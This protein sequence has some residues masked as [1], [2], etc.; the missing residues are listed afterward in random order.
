[1]RWP[2]RCLAILP[3]LGLVLGGG[4]L[5]TE[6]VGCLHKRLEV[7]PD[8]LVGLGAEI[9]FAPMPVVLRLVEFGSVKPDPTAH[10][11]ITFT[12][13]TQLARAG[14]GQELQV[15]QRFHGRAT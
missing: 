14:A 1:V 2:E 15:D 6:Q 13:Y 12:Q 11:Q 7:L 10:V 8:D 5:R 3:S 9:D 4:V